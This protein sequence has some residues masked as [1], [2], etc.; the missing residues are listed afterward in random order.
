M[1]RDLESGYPP[2]GLG[3]FEVLSYRV[4]AIAAD[5]SIKSLIY[6]AH[7]CNIKVNKI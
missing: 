3:L 4:I 5:A 2:K 7:P 1:H 6:D